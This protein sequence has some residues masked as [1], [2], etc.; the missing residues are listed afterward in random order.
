MVIQSENQAQVEAF[1]RVHDAFGLFTFAIL[2]RLTC[3][4]DWHQTHW[5]E[6]FDNLIYNLIYKQ[7]MDNLRNFLT[8]VYLFYLVFRFALGDS[9]SAFSM[10]PKRD[11]SKA[12]K[13][14]KA[15]TDKQPAATGRATRA[16][17]KRDQVDLAEG[18]SFYMLVYP[19]VSSLVLSN[20]VK[21]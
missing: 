16:T 15:D 14:A 21:N 17:K 6:K 19:G 7:K 3:A 12:S 1:S 5:I 8:N 13:T 20:L 4:F 9:Q 2:L 11:A 10:P 18:E